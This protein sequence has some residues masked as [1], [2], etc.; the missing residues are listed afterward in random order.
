MFSST[1]TVR[2]YL[3]VPLLFLFYFFC[4]VL[5]LTLALRQADVYV[6]VPPSCCRLPWDPPLLAASSRLELHVK[7]RKECRAGC[8][9]ICFLP[10]SCL[11]FA[12]VSH[13]CCVDALTGGLYCGKVAF[14][15]PPSFYLSFFTSATLTVT[16]SVIDTCT[17]GLEQH[18]STSHCSS[19]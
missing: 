9:A 15:P 11:A 7:A 17:G 1:V 12:S 5:F 14:S 8:F 13:P 4:F 18:P 3:C 6:V 2:G 19:Q 10:L 16:F